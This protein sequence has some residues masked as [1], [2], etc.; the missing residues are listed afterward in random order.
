MSSSY[1]YVDVQKPG[2]LS[3]LA[4]FQSA[5]TQ[6]IADTKHQ[7]CHI[8]FASLNFRDV[9]LATGQLS[10]DAIPRD[11]ADDD[12]L[13]GMEFSGYDSNGCQ[14]MGVVPSKVSLLIL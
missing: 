3:S 12:V 1:S 11:S 4:W 10:P 7:I 13:L 6:D 2:D 14:I 5:L 8:E 9:M